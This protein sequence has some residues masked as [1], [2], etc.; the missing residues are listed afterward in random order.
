MLTNTD[1]T[2]D[3]LYVL[4][5]PIML[6]YPLRHDRTDK[7]SQHFRG[8][9]MRLALFRKTPTVVGTCTILLSPGLLN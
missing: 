5:V 2:H 6:W 1:T 7:A 8:K 3:T 4:Y 9:N